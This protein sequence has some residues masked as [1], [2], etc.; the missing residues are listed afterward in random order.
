MND[1][2]KYAPFIVIGVVVIWLVIKLSKSG[3]NA[4]V[5]NRVIPVQGEDN[6][7]ALET[8]R[9]QFKL[10][11]LQLQNQASIADKQIEAEK[12]RLSFQNEALKLQG[13]LGLRQL[14][15][16]SN[17]DR[18]L[19]TIAKDTALYSDAVRANAATQLARQNQNE[20]LLNNIFGL[21]SGI[22]QKLL[23]PNQ[24][25]QQPRSSGSG[26]SGGSS[27]GIPMGSGNNSI[28]AAQRQAIQQ[29]AFRRL[30]NMIAGNFNQPISLPNYSL[31]YQVDYLDL[32]PYYD[33][34]AA[35]YDRLLDFGL[36]FDNF[37]LSNYEP[38][39]TV[40]VSYEIFPYEE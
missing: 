26:S 23:N 19:A 36:P 5:V 34:E 33:A 11:E 39:G 24:Q 22:L 29:S 40:D 35:A 25:S 12:Q 1:I 21:G 10:G 14:E 7:V 18:D 30:A 17:R 38:V 13:E 6:T 28:T 20:N 8:L 27:S 31:P 15:L 4:Q 32:I 3:S 2:K 16:Q 9:S 37:E